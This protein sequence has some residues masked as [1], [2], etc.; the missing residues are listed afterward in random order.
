MPGKPPGTHT[1]T[2]HITSSNAAKAI[3]FYK[4]AFGAEEITRSATPD[5]KL[6]HA[7]LRIGDSLL[8]LSDEF[9]EMGGAQAPRGGKVPYVLHTY[10]DNVDQVWDRAVKAGAK[11][12]MPLTNMFWGDR[13][14][15]IEDPFGY[16]WA[17]ATRIEEIT[18]EEAERR[19]KEMFKNF[20]PGKIC[21][22]QE[23][24]TVK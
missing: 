12:V 13:Y 11:V 23:A 10:W 1:I 18:P 24:A 21:A 8:M 16:T 2:P 6:M 9:P 14:G 22:E 7:S 17:M 3:D 19:G 4:N 15:H 20:K 5:G